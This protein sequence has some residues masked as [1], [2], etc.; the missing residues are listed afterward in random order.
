[1]DT[2]PSSLHKNVCIVEQLSRE[3][4]VVLKSHLAQP[5]SL[6]TKL[7]V[8]TTVSHVV[9]HDKFLSDYFSQSWHFLYSKYNID[10]K[11][12]TMCLNCF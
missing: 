1:M 11:S 9:D 3:E 7:F 2:T 6:S 8:F 4:I 5:L 12:N 10:I